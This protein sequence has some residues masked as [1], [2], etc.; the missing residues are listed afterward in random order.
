MSQC[1][2]SFKSWPF[3]PFSDASSS[4]SLSSLSN[5]KQILSMSKFGLLA[6]SNDNILTIFAEEY[7]R[8]TPLS[9]WKPFSRHCITAIGWYDASRCF[10][11]SLPVFVIASE[12][13]H[14]I[15]YDIRS[16][17]AFGSIQRKDDFITSIQWSPH[18]TTDF[19]AGT[20]TGYLL[21]CH[22]I[23]SG[24]SSQL[25][26]QWEIKAS[27]ESLPIDFIC[28]DE[29]TGERAVAVSKSGFVFIVNSLNTD[30]PKLSPEYVK[31]YD[32][33]VKITHCSFFPLHS[34]YLI[35][36]TNKESLLY[37]IEEKC[38]VSFLNIPDIQKIQVSRTLGNK[39]IVVRADTIELWELN[40]ETNSRISSIKMSTTKLSTSSEICLVDM[41]DDTVVLLTAKNWLT[42]VQLRNNKMFVT[43][44][45][46]LFDSQPNDCSFS[47]D[48]FA[49]CMEDGQIMITRSSHPTLVM[50]MS[51]DVK[52]PTK[53][54]RNNST[55]DSHEKLTPSKTPPAK[56]TKG[57]QTKT[58]YIK[59][60]P[61]PAT[62]NSNSPSK[63]TPK[64]TKQG[65]DSKIDSQK[66]KQ[67]QNVKMNLKAGIVDK[68]ID[69]Q[70]SDSDDFINDTVKNEANIPLTHS[71]SSSNIFSSHSTF[72]N[73]DFKSVIIGD[74][75]ISVNS[76]QN[77]PGKGYSKTTD[78]L[79]RP[80]SS[81][82]DR[83]FMNSMTRTFDPLP[84]DGEIL[85]VSILPGSRNK[86]GS[87]QQNNMKCQGESSTSSIKSIALP[88]RM[89]RKRRL[90][91]SL[92]EAEV[93]QQ[94]DPLLSQIAEKS[95]IAMHKDLSFTFSRIDTASHDKVQQNKDRQKKTIFG[96]NC[97]FLWCYQIAENTK[98]NRIELISGTRLL[99]WSQP[100][101]QVIK[102]ISNSNLHQLS[103][104]ANSASS[105]SGQNSGIVQSSSNS[106]IK[107]SL[108]KNVLYMVDLKRHIV[109][110]ILQKSGMYITSVVVSSDKQLFAVVVNNFLVTVFRNRE[111]PRFIG[112][113]TSTDDIV[114]TFIKGMVVVLRSGGTILV[115][116]P[117]DPKKPVLKFNGKRQLVLKNNHGKIIAA[118][119]GPNGI[120][121]GTSTGWVLKVE[122]VTYNIVEICQMKGEI[123]QLRSGPKQIYIARDITGSVIVLNIEGCQSKIK[124]SYKNAVAISPLIVVVTTSK[125]LEAIQ[126]IGHYRATFPTV[127]ARH[128]LMKPRPKWANSLLA[129]DPTVDQ[130]PKYGVPL[131]SKMIIAVKNPRYS[132]ILTELLRNL[133]IK[134][135]ELCHKAFR[136][137]LLIKD[138]KTAK[139]ILTS[140]PPNDPE[141]I[142]SIYKRALFVK[143]SLESEES[144]KVA[145]KALLGA[146][147]YR[148]AID[149]LLISG[150]WIVAVK[151]LITHGRITDA[152][153]VARSLAKNSTIE[154]LKEI[155]EMLISKKTMVSE[156]AIILCEGG[157]IEDA[158]SLLEDMGE[159]EQARVL[160]LSE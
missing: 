41:F 78:D 39:A 38:T 8:Y 116:L 120:I 60:T 68:F 9:M 31:L 56:N 84:E 111:N 1:K 18:S 143:P 65:N 105:N 141:F 110:P 142:N 151:M 148:D 157:F 122:P 25:Q 95:K 47:N 125:S 114:I 152:V 40:K 159:A 104:S 22:L 63:D 123:V 75:R 74:E 61:K 10:D 146:S 132:I 26:I 85:S 16:Q 112:T 131:I 154:V 17:N 150:L 5:P 106:N 50:Q 91:S 158:M 34:T 30:K 81:T 11:V 62:V 64:S 21:K 23:V 102:S 3:P 82:K 103:E 144:A 115:S 93:V 43:R 160:L 45:V 89:K 15:V 33:S 58:N 49:F 83:F 80:Y 35:I 135:P 55:S 121:L 149:V 19:Y 96:N 20:N 4:A 77:S 147:R 7:D 86:S 134:S 94:Q 44:Q 109:T 88:D 52:K 48:S 124:G 97:S 79:I 24:S 53:R 12:L 155:A 136:Y 54:Q 71:G 130:L 137:S 28:I 14:L 90:S 2:L 126:L 37:A 6:Y 128:P 119:G 153:H 145:A 76:N 108:E 87:E 156:A 118:I 73:G 27:E 138:R 133:I 139:Q 46:K 117:I 92:A 59:E 70:D 99:T 113:I 140:C 29:V 98:L 100:I 66:N 129:D 57:D 42:T 67:N 13:G 32:K 127:A 51:W 36:A 69:V 72:T 101:Q 107:N